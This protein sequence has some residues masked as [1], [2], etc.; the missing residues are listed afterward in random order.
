MQ[1]MH[2]LQ[3]PVLIM[4]HGFCKVLRMLGCISSSDMPPPFSSVNLFQNDDTGYNTGLD[5][6]SASTC[7]YQSLQLP[8][9]KIHACMFN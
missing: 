3:M 2:M 6:D 9:R 8:V 4:L 1:Q 5:T 7:S